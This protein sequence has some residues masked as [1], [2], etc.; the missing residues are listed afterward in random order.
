[1]AHLQKKTSTSASRSR[2]STEI[3]VSFSSLHS[4]ML[5]SPNNNQA[6]Y[7]WDNVNRTVKTSTIELM[8]E[9]IHRKQVGP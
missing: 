6:A 8:L 7:K 5:M 3:P 4:I 9:P 1:M 2:K